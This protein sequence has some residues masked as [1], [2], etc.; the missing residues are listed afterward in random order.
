MM[1]K[2]I[3]CES[4]INNSCV[5]PGNCLSYDTLLILSTQRLLEMG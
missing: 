4:N 3:E 5:C 1:T 2:N